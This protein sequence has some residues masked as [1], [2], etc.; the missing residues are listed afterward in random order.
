M[1]SIGSYFV[2]VVQFGLFEL[3]LQMCKDQIEEVLGVVCDIVVK[4]VVDGLIDVE[5]K[6]VKDNFVNGFLLC[7]DSNCKLLDN[8]V[9][10]GWYN[11]LFDYLDIWMQCIVVVM[12]D[13]VCMVFQCVL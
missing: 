4:F 11:L 10:I 13:Q 3:V 8:V 9:N 6:V 7:L 1:Y 12:C 5:L 2:L